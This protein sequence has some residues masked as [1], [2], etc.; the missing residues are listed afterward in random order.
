MVCLELDYELSLVVYWTDATVVLRYLNNTI[1]NLR[2]VAF[3]YFSAA[4]EVCS[5]GCKPG[6]CSIAWSLA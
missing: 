4:V 6:W 5:H 2:T 3:S 1:S